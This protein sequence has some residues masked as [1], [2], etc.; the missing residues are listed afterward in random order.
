MTTSNSMYKLPLTLNASVDT[1]QERLAIKTTPVAADSRDKLVAI[2]RSDDTSVHHK[3]DLLGVRQQPHPDVA[4]ATQTVLMHYFEDD[5]SGSGWAHTETPLP[6]MYDPA[7]KEKLLSGVRALTGFY[8]NGI[9]YLFVQYQSPVAEH[10]S[11]VKIMWSVM[12]NDRPVWHE[13]KWSHQGDDARSVLASVRQ[14][15]VHRRADGQHVLYGIT[16]GFGDPERGL[17]N[18]EFFMVVPKAPKDKNNITV[19]DIAFDTL[20]DTDNEIPGWEGIESA[21]I[22]QLATPLEGEVSADKSRY[23]LLRLRNGNIDIHTTTVTP[24]SRFYAYPQLE[25]ESGSV[26]VDSDGVDLSQAKVLTIPAGLSD[27]VLIHQPDGDLGV[28]QGLHSKTPKYRSLLATNSPAR[29][30]RLSMG[31]TGMI[32]SDNAGIAVYATESGSNRLWILRLNS[33]HESWVCLGDQ[34]SDMVCPRIIPYGSEVFLVSPDAGKIQFKRQHPLTHTWS[35]DELAVATTDLSAVEPVNAHVLDI[36][37]ADAQQIPCPDQKITLRS[38]APCL[39]YVEGIAYRVGPMMPLELTCN[40]YGRIRGVIPANGLKAPEFTAELKGAE[41]LS[42]LPNARIS[43]RLA[44]NAKGFNVSKSIAELAPPEHRSSVAQLIKSYG[45]AASKSKRG[46]DCDGTVR[47]QYRMS[48]ASGG[49]F[50]EETPTIGSAALPGAITLP[51][52]A[53]DI[54]NALRQGVESIAEMVVRVLDASV[55]FLIKIGDEVVKFTSKVFDSIVDGF[56]ALGEFLGQVFEKLG[57]A[58][59]DIGKKILDAVSFI[60]NGKDVFATNDAIQAMVKGGFMATANSA[61]TLGRSMNAEYQKQVD[62]I[63]SELDN[64]INKA[65]QA[66]GVRTQ[67]GEQGLS[68]GGVHIPAPSALAK[69]N[70]AGSD[71]MSGKQD[72]ISSS[73]VSADIPQTEAEVLKNL[74][75]MLHSNV[76]KDIGG[77]IRKIADLV[78]S[79]DSFLEKITAMPFEILHLLK[80]VIKT[81]AKLMGDVLEAALE[82]VRILL[83]RF[84][85]ALESKLDIPFLNTLVQLWSGDQNRQLSF[86][87]IITLPFAFVGTALW[88]IVSGKSLVT[89]EQSTAF[90]PW[91]ENLG[92]TMDLAAV[93]NNKGSLPKKKAQHK[94]VGAA[95]VD[96]NKDNPSHEEIHVFL[97]IMVFITLVTAIASILFGISIQP[98]ATVMEISTNKS[99]V[100]GGILTVMSVISLVTLLV[101][102]I[103]I[104]FY[105]AISGV[106]IPGGKEMNEEDRSVSV[107]ILVLA[108]IGLVLSIMVS[109]VGVY[110]K[111]AMKITISDEISNYISNV[112]SAILGVLTMGWYIY[113]IVAHATGRKSEDGTEQLWGVGLSSASAVASLLSGGAAICVIVATQLMRTEPISGAVMTGV[114]VGCQTAGTLLSSGSTLIG[115]GRELELFA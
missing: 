35:T 8:Q 4:G 85:D 25:F 90:V 66:A 87:D 70:R 114:A 100:L 68:A 106:S 9:T 109:I 76:E 58:I 30:D 20:H 12:E 38:D 19:H 103:V 13:K 96:D 47:K 59:E 65:Q 79:N 67:S 56:E 86:F 18:E 46:V 81:V 54:L 7:S 49:N 84:F 41:S 110:F 99:G 82:L 52:F 75:S 23:T 112:L 71:V 115:S 6:D 42:V 26:R 104:M 28:L 14:L 45:D 2:H 92:T 15:S 80:A 101:T 51:G 32:G 107:V 62:K 29:I 72:Q 74:I 21:G 97:K 64:L 61:A 37:V 27:A 16:R 89:H 73:D 53:G 77:A 105:E 5:T 36:E 60:F 39:M 40:A 78:E 88:K 63:D 48:T 94:S 43:E 3:T 55:E 102:H 24:P 91:A 93:V 69:N 98:I 33:E 11:S 10:S 1:M 31:V 95:A 44:G 113:Q 108:M 111:S 83:G 50:I 22:Y 17:G 57:K 34:V